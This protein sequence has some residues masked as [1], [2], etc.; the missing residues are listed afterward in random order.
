M[1][2]M[3]THSRVCVLRKKKNRKKYPKG[4]KAEFCHCCVIGYSAVYPHPVV[5]GAEP[6]LP[7]YNSV[8]MAINVRVYVYIYNQM[9]KY[10]YARM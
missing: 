2:T 10:T 4:K 3:F 9:Y 5:V 7:R 8:V 6:Q 1:H